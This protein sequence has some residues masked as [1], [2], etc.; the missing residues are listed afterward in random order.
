[1]LIIIFFL[2]YILWVSSL[3][4][5]SVCAK[6]LKNDVKMNHNDS[7]QI[8][9]NH[10]IS[11]L[12]IVEQLGYCLNYFNQVVCQIVR[13]L[14]MRW[15]PPWS[16]F[17]DTAAPLASF[18]TSVQTICVLKVF[19]RMLILCRCWQ[20]GNYDLKTDFWATLHVRTALLDYFLN[21]KLST[22]A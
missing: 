13:W 21:I 9:Q 5:S 18:S 19:K 8:L 7:L 6:I 22:E 15:V 14:T 11:K 2:S 16:W 12:I 4:K 17:R 10:T 1:M 20:S 3:D